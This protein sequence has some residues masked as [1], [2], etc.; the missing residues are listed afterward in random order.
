MNWRY[1]DPW[2]WAVIG[3]FWLALAAAAAFF[4]W[5]ALRSAWSLELSQEVAA[6]PA[7]VFVWLTEG[8][9]RIAWEPALIDYGRLTGAPDAAGATRLLYMRR[10]DLRWRVAEEQ[11]AID[12]PRRWAVARDSRL[13][14]K[15]IAVTLSPL[16]TGAATRLVWRET[17]TITGLR[18]RL[19]GW[20]TLRERRARMASAL[21]RLARLVED[22][23]GG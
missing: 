17:Q 19:T 14:P 16:K 8:E 10:A 6:P 5:Q 23:G 2:E 22:A 18:D 1:R 12:P 11:T 20:F 9:K 15:T 7:A 4:A 13:G 3:L 21:A